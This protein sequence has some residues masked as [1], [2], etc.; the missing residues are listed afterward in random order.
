MYIFVFQGYFG[1]YDRSTQEL[2]SHEVYFE[3]SWKLNVDISETRNF[4]TRFNISQ[5]YGIKKHI[6]QQVVDLD[7]TDIHTQ[8]SQEENW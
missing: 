2:L 3:L 8:I 7:T 5:F 4:Q 6:G 1:L